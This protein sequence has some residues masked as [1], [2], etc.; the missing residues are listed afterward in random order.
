MSKMDPRENADKINGPR[1]PRVKT[2][3]VTSERERDIRKEQDANHEKRN[4]TKTQGTDSIVGTI[5]LKEAGK[6]EREREQALPMAGRS[7]EGRRYRDEKSQV[8]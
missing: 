3:L 8:I 1:E 7:G 2:H 4:C 6:G 5:A